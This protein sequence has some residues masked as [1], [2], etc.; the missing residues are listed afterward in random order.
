MHG[1]AASALRMVEV[2]DT[3]GHKPRTAF[4]GRLT[5]WGSSAAAQQAP[6]YISARAPHAPQLASVD[7]KV[8][9]LAATMRT[10]RIL[11]QAGGFAGF[12]A[13]QFPPTPKGLTVLK[14]KFHENVTISF[15]EVRLG[16]AIWWITPR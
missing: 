16:S 12:G 2:I 8:S 15:K 13:A 5:T 9:E 11:I 14:S 1:L 7:I 6:A 3:A 4:A 10:W